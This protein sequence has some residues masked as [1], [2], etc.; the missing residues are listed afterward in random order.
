MK[1]IALTDSEKRLVKMLSALGNPAR[2]K[3]F[4]FLSRYP[5]RAVG[6]VV[7]QTPLAQST[8]SQH[9][10]V[11]QEAGLIH[12]EQSGTSRCCTLNAEALR[13]LRKQIAD[14]ASECEVCDER[15]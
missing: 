8:V 7:E 10:K 13:W 3:M 5:Q 4:Q 11:L 1:Q 14:L 2:F 6:N 9:L 15:F 12:G